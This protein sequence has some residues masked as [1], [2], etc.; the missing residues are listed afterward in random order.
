MAPQLSAAGRARRSSAAAADVDPRKRGAAALSVASNSTLIVL[1]LVAGILTGSVAV[2]T[3]ALH[4]SVDLIA[5]AV[6][7]VSIRKAE[8]PAD[9]D[10]RYGHEKFENM[11]AAIEGMLILVGSAVIAYTSI[12]H[13]V[14]G[15]RVQ[16]LGIGMAVVA[17]SALVNLVVSGVLQ[18]RARETESAALEGD[19]AHLRTDAATSVAVL[20]GLGMVQLTGASWID[21]GVALAVAAYIVVAGLRIL[22]RSSRAL[23]DEALPVEELEAIRA[24]VVGF[25]DRGVAGFHKLRTRRAGARR[26]VD[27]HVQFRSGTTLEVAHRTAHALQGA[28]AARLR[29]VDVLIHLEPEDRVRPG[30]EIPLRTGRATTRSD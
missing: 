6:A 30:T 5:S 16:R 23:V 27:L 12:V 28:I 15:S 2:L 9:E 11:A 26:Y 21:A 13:L 17:V 4:S 10:H 14:N 29:N 20:V 1:K 19:A 24:E 22:S 3:E 8:R 18:R 25:G 7:F